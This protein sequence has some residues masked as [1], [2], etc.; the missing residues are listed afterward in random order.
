VVLVALISWILFH[1][2]MTWTQMAG[3][4]LVLV[5]VGLL[6]LGGKH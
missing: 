5:G 3:I 4:A 1:E 6:E 2:A